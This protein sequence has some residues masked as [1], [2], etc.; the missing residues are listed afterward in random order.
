MPAWADEL[1]ASASSTG[2]FIDLERWRRLLQTG[3]ELSDLGFDE[4]LSSAIDG[5]YD[6]ELFL[7]SVQVGVFLRRS[8]AAWAGDLDHFDHQDPRRSRRTFE[9]ASRKHRL[10][11]TSGSRA[12]QQALETQPSSGQP[13]G[14]AQYLLKGLKPQR[15]EKRRYVNSSPSSATH[16]PTPCRAS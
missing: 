2:C 13:R 1:V 5:T 11:C 9:T 10:S 15:G 6:H 12:H 4:A 3:A 16:C 7:R 8:A 14:E